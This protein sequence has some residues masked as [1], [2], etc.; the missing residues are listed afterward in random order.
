ME[1]KIT[2]ESILEKANDTTL[3]GKPV[4]VLAHLDD[5]DLVQ[6]YDLAP[7]MSYLTDPMDSA[8][9]SIADTIFWAAGV[10]LEEVTE[11]TF[12]DALEAA[13]EKLRGE[14]TM[15]QYRVKPE[16]LDNWLAHGDSADEVIVDENEINRL[17]REWGMS[18]EDLMEQVEEC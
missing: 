7:D 3:Q 18:V 13:V 15:K 17:A 1:N 16:Y 5:A 10:N 6:L 11:D 12:D 14:G 8:G 4:Q 9:K 2:F